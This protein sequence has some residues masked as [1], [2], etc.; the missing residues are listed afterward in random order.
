MLVTTAGLKQPR[1]A[2]FFFLLFHANPRRILRANSFAVSF[3]F[4]MQP[5]GCCA[6]TKTASRSEK[7]FFCFPHGTKTNFCRLIR[8]LPQAFS[9]PLHCTGVG[10]TVSLPQT[11]CPCEASRA[12]RGVLSSRVPYLFSHFVSTFCFSFFFLFSHFF[13]SL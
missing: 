10:K 7:N 12:P 4:R 9:V 11:L 6:R 1:A 2:K 3:I 8:F 5:N 13:L